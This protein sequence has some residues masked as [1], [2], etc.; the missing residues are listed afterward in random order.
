MCTVPCIY[1]RLYGRSWKTNDDSR[2]MDNVMIYYIIIYIYSIH[3]YQA[4]H[5]C[6][7]FRTVPIISWMF[8]KY[9]WQDLPCFASI[10]VMFHEAV[11]ICARAS[12]LNSIC[13][14]T[15]LHVDSR[16]YRPFRYP[17]CCVSASACASFF[18][19]DWD[20]FIASKTMTTTSQ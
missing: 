13:A 17:R 10:N 7:M 4:T 20:F 2:N 18:A 1:T 11:P 8:A 19:S 6:D 15:V 3:I 9:V 14:V 16:S 5:H 12:S